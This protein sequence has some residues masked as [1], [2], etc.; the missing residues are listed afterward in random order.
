[1]QINYNFIEALLSI[2]L[3]NTEF[4]ALENGPEI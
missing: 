1:M 2:E 3:A 4:Y